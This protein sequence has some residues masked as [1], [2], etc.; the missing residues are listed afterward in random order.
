LTT[1][2]C[3]AQLGIVLNGCDTDTIGHK[4]GGHRVNDCVAWMMWIDDKAVPEPSLGD[5]GTAP[6]SSDGPVRTLT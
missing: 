2:E 1:D 3:I 5:P 4:N 6:T